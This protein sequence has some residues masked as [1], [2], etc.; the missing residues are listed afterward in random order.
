MRTVS[1]AYST[2]RTRAHKVSRR[3]AGSFC[4]RL[5]SLVVGFCFWSTWWLPRGIYCYR[6][7]QWDWRLS[8]SP[9]TVR[10]P[11]RSYVEGIKPR[12]KRISSVTAVQ[13]CFRSW[14]RPGT[15]FA[16]TSSRRYEKIPPVLWNPRL[17]RPNV[18]AHGFSLDS[19]HPEHPQN[20]FF[21]LV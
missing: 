21:S 1:V 16:H 20:L 19:E 18:Y 13:H 6:C 17:S 15:F 10:Q 7:P 2:T 12:R 8:C 4:L 11:P 9:R 3:A 14:A 5:A